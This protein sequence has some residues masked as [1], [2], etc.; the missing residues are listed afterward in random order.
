VS[1]LR[2]TWSVN[3]VG[4]EFDLGREGVGGLWYC[5]CLSEVF[6]Y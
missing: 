4:L 6:I 1:D 5:A 3:S 2:R